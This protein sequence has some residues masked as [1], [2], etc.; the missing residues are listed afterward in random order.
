[1]Q[2]A[3]TVL[4]WSS[5]SIRCHRCTPL[6]PGPDCL[7]GLSSSAAFFSSAFLTFSSCSNSTSASRLGSAAGQVL[8]H[9]RL[10]GIC[11]VPIRRIARNRVAVGTHVLGAGGG[12]CTSLPTL[13]T[14]G[15][16][17]MALLCTCERPIRPTSPSFLCAARYDASVEG[18]YK[19]PVRRKTIVRRDARAAAVGHSDIGLR[20]DGRM[21]AR[22]SIR[23]SHLLKRGLYRSAPAPAA[24][25]PCAEQNQRRSVL[26]IFIF[27]PAITGEVINTLEQVARER[28]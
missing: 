4:S 1:M 23:H 25:A 21:V 11:P 19:R 10:A 22:V 16:V 17:I 2:A 5:Q 24:T 27:I 26:S 15:W 18:F 6:F 9:G 28:P 13:A 3:G 20:S 12:W 7:S 14:F 8:V